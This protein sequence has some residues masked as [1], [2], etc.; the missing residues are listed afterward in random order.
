MKAIR[1]GS[2]NQFYCTVTEKST[3]IA[4]YWLFRFVSDSAKTEVTAILTNSSTHTNRYDKFAITE[5]G[6]GI[7]LPDGIHTYYIYEQDNDTNTDYN[8]ATTLCEVGQVKVT[9]TA[10]IQSTYPDYSIESTYTTQ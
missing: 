9:G 8:L 4:P 3:L 10:I 2:T 7:T 1:K 6:Y 5:G